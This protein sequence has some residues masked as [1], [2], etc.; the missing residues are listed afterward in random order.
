MLR[1]RSRGGGE[2]GGFVVDAFTRIVSLL[3]E[4]DKQNAWTVWCWW[5]PI[6]CGVVRLQIALSRMF[7]S[8]YLLMVKMLHVAS[9]VVCFEVDV[10]SGCET[11]FSL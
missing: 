2:K 10:A 3:S 8:V 4:I 1:G 11:T 9:K 5:P 7:L 6:A